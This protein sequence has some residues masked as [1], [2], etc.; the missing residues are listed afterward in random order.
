MQGSWLDTLPEKTRSCLETLPE[1]VVVLHHRPAAELSQVRTW[2]REFDH[3]GPA[4]GLDFR[5]VGVSVLDRCTVGLLRSIASDRVAWLRS[6]MVLGHA[7]DRNSSACWA[8]FRV[9]ARS[10]E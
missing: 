6:A 7:F 8:S 3:T 5:I 4:I 2:E 9:I 1:E 10:L